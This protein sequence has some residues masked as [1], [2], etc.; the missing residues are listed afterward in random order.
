VWGQI[1]ILVFTFLHKR[2]ISNLVNANLQETKT[3][4]KLKGCLIPAHIRISA[5]NLCLFSVTILVTVAAVSHFPLA[6]M[7]VLPSGRIG[8]N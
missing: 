4:R 6:A 5:R 2:I 8:A 7:H 1:H 3:W